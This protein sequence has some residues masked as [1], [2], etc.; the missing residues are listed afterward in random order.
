MTLIMGADSEQEDVVQRLALERGAT[1]EFVELFIP[2]IYR[3][4]DRY[5]LDAAYVVAQSFKETAG[6]KFIGTVPRWFNNLAGIKVHPDEQKALP[7]GIGAG[8]A[9]WAHQRYAT[10]WQGALGLAQHLRAYCGKKVPQDEVVSPRYFYVLGRQRITRW[11][12]ITWAGPGYGAEVV[13]LARDFIET[14]L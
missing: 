12:D 11:E 7:N 13:R 9:L 2:L 10:P 1:G 4:C 3:A 5:G 14:G 6:G 8:N